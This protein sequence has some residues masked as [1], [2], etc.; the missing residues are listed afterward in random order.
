M[1]KIISIQT[2][3]KCQQADCELYSRFLI[4]KKTEKNC[5]IGDICHF[6]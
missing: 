6:K 3:D 4:K 5:N 2:V 1:N